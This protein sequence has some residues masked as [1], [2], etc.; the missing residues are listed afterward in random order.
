MEGFWFWMLVL[1]LVLA[2]FAWPSW[3]Y[4]RDRRVY[5]RGGGWAYGISAAAVVAALLLAGLFWLG[6]IVIWMPFAA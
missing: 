6:L 4:T 5:R 2:F 3:P 1:L